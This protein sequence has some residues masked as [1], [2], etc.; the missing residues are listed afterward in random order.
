MIEQKWNLEFMK[1]KHL[2]QKNFINCKGTTSVLKFTLNFFFIYLY[3]YILNKIWSVNFWVL[4][5]A[6]VLKES[7]QKNIAHIY[8]KN[9]QI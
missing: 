8:I 3:I 4:F 7:R 1:P 6:L 5:I 2:A 9:N